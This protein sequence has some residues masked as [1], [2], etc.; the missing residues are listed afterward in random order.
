MATHEANHLEP[1]YR[2]L[3]SD[4][5]P[6][7]SAAPVIRQLPQSVVNK[8]A[9]G[10]VIERPAS[11]VKELLE[12][13]LDAGSTRIDVSLGQGGLDLIRVTD[14]GCGL[15]P[16][17][18]PLALAS[19]AT[20]KIHDADDL[21]HVATFGFRGEALASIAEVSHLRLR[22]RPHE[23]EQACELEVIGGK[24]SPITPC[25]A[26]PGT[27]LE[28][29]NLFFNTPVRRK[30]MR[31]SQTEIGHCSEAFTRIALAHERVHFTLRHNEK[32][33]FDL[34]P[35]ADWR[36]RI[37]AL[38]GRDLERSLIPIASGDGDV[39][40][41]GYVCDPQ[42]SRSNNR[43]Q[44][45]FLNGRHIRD[46]SLQHALGEA[47]RGLLLHGR[48]PIGF[49]RLQMPAEAVD[50]NVHPTKLEVRFQDSG[51]IYSLVL[52]TIRKKFLATDLTAKVRMN[53]GDNDAETAALDPAALEQHRRDLVDW[54]T[55]A[56][57]ASSA[58]MG[59]Q[60]SLNVATAGTAVL[61]ED[62]QGSLD[63]QFERA[64][65]EAL[66]LNTLDRSWPAAGRAP[67]PLA[68]QIG[69]LAHPPARPTLPSISH[70]GFQIHN[71]YLVTQTDEGMVVIDQHALHE[72][73]LYEQVR[74]KV[75]S[76]KMETQRLLV[77]EPV[78]L[79]PNEVAAALENKALLAQLGMEVEPFGGDTVLL[80][81]YPAMLANLG[82][83]EMLRQVVDQI[84][85]GGK[86]PDRR[87]LLNDLLN[88]IACKAAIKAG[89]RL[90]P[91]EITALLEQREHYQDAHHCPHGRPTALVFTREELDRR[92]KR[93]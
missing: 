58:E 30:F 13:A 89:D 87:D 35:V 51:R 17:Q 83:A 41:Q 65:G 19:H 81:S 90:A 34:P 69:A 46:R 66:Q 45:L 11:V 55:G 78:T 1:G 44:Y 3:A 91:E 63:L 77:P 9:A 42:Q 38:C 82:P 18:M 79:P 73:I 57:A 59:A 47:Y 25:G 31:A 71:R 64:S 39:H 74:A 48:F 85:A 22:S 92:F 49:L 84:V 61:D 26:A 32:T 76:G 37:A 52:G 80:S 43:M 56:L 86:S 15:S 67:S 75:M 5:R 50:V 40:L 24:S 16:E 12:N 53:G 8:I 62:A 2:S 20:S 68:A 72:R 6:P 29:R 93:T 70:L 21:F 88:M 60:A 28:I 33:I 23:S 54:A 27:M 10:E 7:T 4:F 14:N 36:E